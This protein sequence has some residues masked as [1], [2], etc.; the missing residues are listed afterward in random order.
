MV[1]VDDRREAV[2]GDEKI[3]LATSLSAMFGHGLTFSSRFI[4]TVG[5]IATT[6]RSDVPGWLEKV[7]LVSMT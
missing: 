4:R 5:S 2:V 7:V 6:F 3:A 1:G